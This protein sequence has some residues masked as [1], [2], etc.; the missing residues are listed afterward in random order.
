MQAVQL[1]SALD[2]KV[3]LQEIGAALRRSDESAYSAYSIVPSR[4]SISKLPS[5]TSNESTDMI[6]RRLSCEDELS[7]AK[8][9]KKNYRN[10]LIH[11]LFKSRRPH[12]RL[13]TTSTQWV[14]ELRMLEM[15]DVEASPLPKPHDSFVVE[16]E[17]QHAL[18]KQR[19]ATLIFD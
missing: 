4:R 2:R 1:K 5:S 10:S 3:K 16:C 11:Q 7:T 18:R 12:R 13:A 17:H 14:T 9:Y 19:G 6:Y 8:V 15:A